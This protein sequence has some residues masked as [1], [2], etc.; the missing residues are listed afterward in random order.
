MT[1]LS[2]RD[3]TVIPPGAT[4]PVVE[5]L[6]LE[7]AAGEWLA[8]TGPNGG[9][10]SALLLGLAELWPT[11]GELRLDGELFAPHE[12][13]LARRRLAV[14]LQDP[15]TQIL[16][17]TVREEIAFGLRNR[18]VG[19]EE[20]QERVLHW[21]GALDLDHD[22]DRDPVNLS[23]GRQQMVLLA[24]AL[25]SEPSVLLAD[26]ATAHL[27]PPSRRRVLSLVAE[28]A[29]LGLSIV[30]VTQL[31][32]E[33]AAAHR[34]LAL[35]VA[36]PT[37]PPAR[38]TTPSGPE[39]LRIHLRARGLAEG[40]R[41]MIDRPM[42][43]IV[44]SRGVTGVVG[45]N[46]VGKSVLLG[47]VAGHTPNDQVL[48][49]WVVPPVPPPIATL[50]F[51]E[52][53]IFEESPAAEVAYAAVSRGVPPATALGLARNCL[54][55]LQMDP[56]ELFARRTWALSTGEKR[57]LEVVAA[58]ISP[59]CLHV[60]DE[61]TAGLDTP[62]RA[63]LGRLITRLAEANPVLIATQD[64]E[65]LRGIGSR[66]VCLGGDPPEARQTAWID[67]KTH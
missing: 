19:G 27:D 51:P 28:Q 38:Q 1:R 35:G 49:S 32:D 67:L 5:R 58:L 48:I 53:Q 45:R 50:Q 33:L 66:I 57:I 64:L 16:Q 30:W 62:R 11:R 59:S 36:E 60:L 65:W 61:P 42:D 44:R 40:P 31:P 34:R 12:S 10:K 6:S 14:V 2:A 41:V 3:L 56:D 24:A 9:G 37:G 54:R 4:V 63:A 26:E 29:A 46:G 43:L 52:L 15:S 47:A 18:G 22:L 13:P 21:S 23:A 17:P 25:A 39:R 55:D 8:V 20:L 7:V